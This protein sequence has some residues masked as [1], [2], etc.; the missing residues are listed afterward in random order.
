MII[1]RSRWIRKL[2]KILQKN[3]GLHGFQIRKNLKIRS[4]GVDKIVYN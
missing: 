4:F 3:L 1:L 2:T